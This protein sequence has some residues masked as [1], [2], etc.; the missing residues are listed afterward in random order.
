[1][2]CQ[3]ADMEDVQGGTRLPVFMAD[4]QFGPARKRDFLGQVCLFSFK[5]KKEIPRLLPENNF[6]VILK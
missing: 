4:G 3:L 6:K 5:K 2:N 1:M